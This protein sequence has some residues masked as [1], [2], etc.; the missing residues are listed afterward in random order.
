MRVAHV[1]TDGPWA[2]PAGGHNADASPVAMCMWRK[3]G[4]RTSGRRV[5]DGA[6]T[7]GRRVVDGAHTSGR[8]VVDGAHTSGRHVVDGA[9]TSGR[10]VIT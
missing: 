8:H 1:L 7:S 3:D 2:F 6:R 5:I 9:R 10:R 4:A